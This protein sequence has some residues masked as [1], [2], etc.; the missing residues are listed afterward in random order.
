MDVYAVDNVHAP[1][2][3]DA[4]TGD[5]SIHVRALPWKQRRVKES[6]ALVSTA[7]AGWLLPHLVRERY[8]IVV[9]AGLR[10]LLVSA[11]LRPLF[12]VP[13]VYFSLELYLKPR[14]GRTVW[15]LFKWVER[16]ALQRVSFVIIQDESRA[17]VLSADSG[18]ALDRITVLPNATDGQAVVR[19][20]DYLRKRF[21]IAEGLRVLLYAG[22]IAPWAMVKELVAAARDLPNDWVLVVHCG[23][24]PIEQD[25]V[26][27]EAVRAASPQGRALFSM[28]PLPARLFDDLVASAD[29][30]VAM[31]VSDDPNLNTMGLSSGKVA[32][33][34]KFGLPVIVNGVDG[35][36]TLVDVYGCGA[37]VKSVSDLGE[38]VARIEANY[39]VAC[40][41]S[42]RCFNEVLAPG[43]Y[44]DTLLR[45]FAA[46][47]ARQRAWR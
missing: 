42:A 8:S 4:I 19:R 26:Y 46:V 7:F 31:Y 15:R 6:A 32:Q 40:A 3:S 39:E 37:V 14:C 11:L 17:A 1:S 41:A 13:V 18:V 12:R 44:K 34:L 10:G 43:R 47:V 21:S 24:P 23:R 45:M 9:A 29:A 33:Y 36:K 28:T 2:P 27:W 25:A 30:G 22:S 20:S 16:A 35:L 38:A 5:H